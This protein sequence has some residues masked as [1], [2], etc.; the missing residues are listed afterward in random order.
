MQ[1]LYGQRSMYIYAG[2][3]G[4]NPKT[5]IFYIEIIN[6][7]IKNPT[8]EY[9]FVS[10]F[11]FNGKCY[12]T[13]HICL[14]IYCYKNI[15]MQMRLHYNT[16]VKRGEWDLNPRVLTNMGLAIPRPTR[17]GDPRPIAVKVKDSIVLY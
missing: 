15:S 13:F 1:V 3:Q 10:S 9:S 12:C 6:R 16:E 7:L 11:K 2:V 17:L 14:S 4:A 8:I 5:T